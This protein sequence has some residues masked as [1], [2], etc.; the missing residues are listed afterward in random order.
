M[1]SRLIRRL[2]AAAGAIALAIGVAGTSSAAVRPQLTGTGGIGS[3][4]LNP[5]DNSGLYLNYYG[6]NP[7]GYVDVDTPAAQWALEYQGCGTWGTGADAQ[8]GCS[9]EI[10]SGGMCLGDTVDDNLP[11]LMQCGADGTSW[12]FVDNGTGSYLIY[13]RYGLNQ[14]GSNEF[15]DLLGDV[16]YPSYAQDAL[17]VFSPSELDAQGGT[18]PYSITWQPSFKLGF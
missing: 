12:V 6:T 11:S 15:A 2:I 3:L 14:R 8:T 16:S 5:N 4:E 18:G 1:D 7:D 10:D 13:D 9:Y 17:T